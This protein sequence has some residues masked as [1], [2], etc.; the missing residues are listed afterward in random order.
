MITTNER[1]ALHRKNRKNKSQLEVSQEMVNAFDKIS[2]SVRR[3]HNVN[4]CQQDN[5]DNKM[6]SLENEHR[7][8]MGLLA[9]EQK[10]F[11]REQKSSTIPL[12]PQQK[13]QKGLIGLSKLNATAEKDG[14]KT[15]SRLPA[16]VRKHKYMDDDSVES[17]KRQAL[18]REKFVLKRRHSVQRQKINERSHYNLP[19]IQGTQLN[20]AGQYKVK[21]A[22]IGSNRDSVDK[23][24]TNPA[25]KTKNIDKQQY[26]TSWD[27]SA[28]KE[29][30]KTT[31]ESYNK[32]DKPPSLNSQLCMGESSYTKP[33]T[34][35]ANCKTVVANSDDSE[36]TF[37]G[38]SKGT[39]IKTPGLSNR[40]L[41]FER[42]GTN[43]SELESILDKT[44]EIRVKQF[45]KLPPIG[46]I[47]ES[48]T[49]ES[50]H[51]DVKDMKSES[52]GDKRSSQVDFDI[53]L[54]MRKKRAK[55]SLWKNLAHCRYLRLGE[56]H[57]H[58][59]KITNKKCECNWC[60]MVRKTRL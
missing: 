59:H 10:R 32:L 14:M 3:A 49:S 52:L 24:S 57:F 21:D 20:K 44:T 1:L 38:R 18:N 28:S 11:L 2:V 54:E 6:W 7:K 22:T 34:N 15:S 43:A 29:T 9:R 36:T 45:L 12:Q 58:E 42:N 33:K 19:S 4:R 60:A 56:Q 16:L 27:T 31:A 5:L 35:A 53:S 23:M 55:S 37:S 8:S 47:H 46:G 30:F 48:P 13:H 39:N 26:I 25:I 17:F 40:K 41:H 51:G 50:I